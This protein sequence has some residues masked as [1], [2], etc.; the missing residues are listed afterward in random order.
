MSLFGAL[1]TAVSGLSAQAGAFTNISD[2]VA[3]SQTVGFKGINTSFVDYLSSSTATQNQS[4]SVATRPSYQNDVQGQVTTST[5]ATAMAIAGKGFFQV[6]VQSGV[7]ATGVPILNATPNYTRTGDFTQDKS[8]YLVNSAGGYLNGW[9]VDANG[10]VLQ[11]TLSPIKISQAQNPPVVTANVA[12]A[13]NL[14]AGGTTG[15]T[16]AVTAYDAAGA[17]HSLKLTWAPA[18]NAGAPVAN[19]WTL[20]VTE[21]GGTP[22]NAGTAQ[23][24]P[25]GTIQSFTASGTGGA[26]A[27]TP[28][29]ATEAGFTLTPSWAQGGPINV[30]LGTINGTDGVTQFASTTYT[31]RNITADGVTAGNYTGIG[32]NADGSVVANYDNGTTR[33][34]AQVPVVTFGNPDALQRQNGEAFTTTAASGQPTVNVQNSNGA[35]SLAVGQVESSNVDIA[36]ELTKLIVAQQAYGA[37]AKMITAANQMLTTTINTIQ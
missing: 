14:P 11:G 26:A 1:N 19:Q 20:S 30:N 12:V 23:F 16:S 7:T 33:T 17:Q 5:D 35:G 34:L 6:S 8:G 10:T 21:D 15:G 3:N 37:N 13:A 28:A 32:I 31:S 18:M 29:S 27:L 25:N 22:V 36:T 24:N 4:G 9:P 2:N